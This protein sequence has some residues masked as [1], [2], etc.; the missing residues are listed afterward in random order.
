[1]YVHYIQFVA[2][3]TI[4]KYKFCFRFFWYIRFSRMDMCGLKQQQNKKKIREK[5]EYREKLPI[6]YKKKPPSFT[7]YNILLISMH[8]YIFQ[9][10][11]FLVEFVPFGMQSKYSTPNLLISLHIGTIQFCT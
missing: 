4:I 3:N 11:I 2:Y 7:I 6:A 5:P 10:L 1:M 9:L 8:K